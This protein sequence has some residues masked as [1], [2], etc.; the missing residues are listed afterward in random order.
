MTTTPPIEYLNYILC[1]ELGWTYRDLM[2]QPKSFVDEMLAIMEIKTKF[3]LKH[4]R[5]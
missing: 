3:D 5:R 4:G 2:E 1:K